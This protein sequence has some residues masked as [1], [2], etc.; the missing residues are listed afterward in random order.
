MSD[1]LKGFNFHSAAKTAKVYNKVPEKLLLENAK[2]A[3]LAQI[4]KRGLLRACYQPDEF[5]SAFINNADP[6]QLVGFD[7]EMAH[8]FSETLR[9]PLE[10]LPTETESTAKTFLDRG[11]CDI[12]MRTLPVT[13]HRSQE[14]GL[15]IPVYRS[16][17]GLV[18]LDYRRN[19]FRNWEDIKKNDEILRLGVEGSQGNAERLS[20]ITSASIIP[21]ENKD[22]LFKIVESREEDIDAIAGLAEEAAALTI[23]YPHFSHVVPQPPIFLPVSYAVALGNDD[24]L[25]IANSWILMTKEAGL[26]DALYRHWM[27]GEAIEK[28][29]LP[30]WSIIR[31]ALGWVE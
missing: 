31:N 7:I 27:L 6:P 5:P 12:Y 28:D 8:H 19:E 15:T 4:E 25:R 29:K 13:P 11:V 22:H 2:P 18:V 20:K 9:L 17:L 23:V 10:L 3:S 16:S 24:L 1:M 21:I 14:L 30:R 26:I